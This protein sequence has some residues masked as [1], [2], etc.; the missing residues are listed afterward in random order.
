MRRATTRRSLLRCAGL[1]GAGLATGGVLPA[2]VLA[3][4][5]AP[6]VITSERM[7]PRLP[8]GV[9][10]GDLAG[11][12]AIIWARADRPARMMVEWATTERFA[13]ARLV[14]GPAALEDTD[15]AVK[16]DLAGLPPG[17]RVFYR[18][19]MI[20]L[21]DHKLASE[22]VAGSFW[23]PP[24]APARR[25]LR[26]V[27]RYRRA[28]LGDQPRMGRHEDLRDHA[29]GRAGVLHPLGR[30]DLCR[31]A[32]R[33]RA[34]DAGWR[35]LA[36][37]HHRG[38]GQGRR[39]ARR[40]PRQL[41]LQPDGRARARASTP[42]RRCSPSGTTTTSPTTG[43][44]TRIWPAIRRRR[45]QGD[46]RRSVGGARRAGVHGV[47]A[48]AP[49]SARSGAAVRGVRLWPLA[50]RLPHRHALLSRPQCGERP[51]P[52]QPRHCVPRAPSRSA[53]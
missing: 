11:D 20:D 13:D 40:V 25:P 34:G 5:G 22:P 45:L 49:A 9:Q 46:Q 29:P 32:D 7:R 52:T 31:R 12:R 37:S 2:R 50:R 36:Q 15:F 8:Y 35:R 41:R 1:A 42:R 27:G 10:S 17:E 19:V 38:Q 16:L 33:G 14:R 43:T 24:V 53:G 6:A 51:G 21:A 30:R 23:T 48:G 4:A 26:V 44:R 18:V 3:Q 28:G 39:D 47:H